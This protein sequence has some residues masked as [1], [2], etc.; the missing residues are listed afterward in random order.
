[1]RQLYTSKDLEEYF[2]VTRYAIMQWR[3]EGMPFKKIGGVIR[4][5]M[6]AVNKWVE[7]QNKDKKEVK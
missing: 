5:D 6:E 4:F 3:E 1:M 2:Q 7:E